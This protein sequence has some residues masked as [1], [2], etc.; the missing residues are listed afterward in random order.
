MS[1]IQEH[2]SGF[3]SGDPLKPHD[4][5]ELVIG[6]VAPV[7]AKLTL[8]CDVLE[9]ELTKFGYVS[10]IVRLSKLLPQLK[11]YERL[12]T[13]KHPSEYERVSSYM[14]AGTALRS[15][16][17]RGDIMA[18]LSVSKIRELRE[19]Q[20][21]NNSSIL[22]EDRP[23]SPLHRT[24]YILRSL[25]HPDEIA[26]LRSV[27]GRAF[28]L[29]SAY[30]PRESRIDSLAEVIAR[31]ANKSDT[32]AYRK[33][34]EELIWI[35][36]QEQGTKLG[37]NVGD[38]FPLA[39]LFIDTR[40]RER[41]EESVT[42]YFELVFG[43]PFHTP[44]RDEYAMFHAKAAALRSA[45][46]SRQVGAAISTKDGDIIAVGC[47]EVP[48]AFGGLYWPGD[49]GEDRDFRRG[50]DSS[51]KSKMDI[52]SEIL[53]KFA[54]GGWLSEEKK[55]QDVSLL[56]K[57]LLHGSQEGGDGI[58]RDTQIARLLEF[59]RP[60]HAEMA[61]LMDAARRGVEV[62]GCTL[63][64]TTFPCHICARHIIASGISR[65]VY[66]EPYPKSAT[67]E[68]Y[69]D[70]VAIDTPYAVP[71]R[72][73]FESFVGIAPI[74]YMTLFEIHGKRKDSAGKAAEWNKAKANP[75]VKRFVLSYLLIEDDIVGDV[76]PEL[77]KK[78]GINLVQATS[79]GAPI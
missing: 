53:E 3:L 27:Y 45:D 43:H 58:L 18:L 39:D 15:L 10:K 23:R 24:A 78:K 34:A 21:E 36:E 62:K 19:E 70:S 68:L 67:K 54:N 11:P 71:D 12:A 40:S 13:E 37:Q 50:Y 65:V 64:T 29:V 49:P 30:A 38:A 47:N 57:E 1:G 56:V 9:A 4:G 44:T 79:G 35:D 22:A 16:T 69:G 8:V 60:V 2:S 41:I 61:A 42:R 76:L 32:T 26:T 73:R 7:G 6:V 52:L 51:A 55:K 46:L 75:R 5:P 66:I 63:Y 20:N 48:R 17:E 77:L 33:Q 14:K 25:K 31:S 74:R 72:V 59:G 28:L